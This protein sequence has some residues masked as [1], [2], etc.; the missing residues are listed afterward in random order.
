MVQN[1][2]SHKAL[3]RSWPREIDVLAKRG[4]A[5]FTGIKI[6]V[7][8]PMLTDHICMPEAPA[9]KLYRASPRR[10]IKCLNRFGSYKLE[11]SKPPVLLLFELP[12]QSQPAFQPVNTSEDESSAD[13]RP[14]LK[15][16]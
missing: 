1:P 7:F 3:V 9:A 14:V 16:A 11:L 12:L 5:A 2:V 6:E 8:L 15:S 4:G 13:R 10:W